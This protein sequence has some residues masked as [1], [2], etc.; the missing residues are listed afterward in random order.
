MKRQCIIEE[1]NER[2]NA[3]RSALTK[4]ACSLFIISVFSLEL[5]ATRKTVFVV[6]VDH[7]GKPILSSKARNRQGWH[8]S[9]AG[10]PGELASILWSQ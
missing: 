6:V 2:S 1:L 3:M 9:T 7:G 10:T 5:Y 8:G 4:A